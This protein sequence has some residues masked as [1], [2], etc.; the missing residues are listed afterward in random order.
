MASLAESFA[1]ARMDGYVV[2]HRAYGGAEWAYRRWCR[3][4][5]RP[6][7]V[8]TFHGKTVSGFLNFDTTE[9][10]SQ[11][12][13]VGLMGKELGEPG[14]KMIR[15]F[16]DRCPSPRVRLLWGGAGSTVVEFTGVPVSLADALG[17]MLYTAA[18]SGAEPSAQR[19]Q[20]SPLTS[21][22]L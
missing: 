1:R 11:D 9:Y 4:Q 10:L 13:C 7:V 5:R 14:A 12:P 21:A 2:N 6:L 20:R 3:R 18:I 19:A 22:D 8:V 16:F 17:A 15:E